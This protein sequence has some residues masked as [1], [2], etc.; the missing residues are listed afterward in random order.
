MHLL[1]RLPVLAL[2]FVSTAADA[3]QLS[4]V[5]KRKPLATRGERPAAKLRLLDLEGQPVDPFQPTNVKARVFI[6]VSNE[7]PIANRYAPEIR[8]LSTHFASNAIPFCLVHPEPD[9]TPGSIAKHMKDYQFTCRVLRDPEH[10]LVT[11]ARARVT[12]EAAV[13]G[14]DSQLLYHGRIDNRYVDF[15]KMR[16]AATEHDLQNVLEAIVRGKSVPVRETRAVGCYI[17]KLP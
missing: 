2:L 14:P 7:C 16:P 4:D 9:E 1:M 10:L 12:P 17:S 3:A 15:G 8:R 11:R 6:F 5:E 13:F